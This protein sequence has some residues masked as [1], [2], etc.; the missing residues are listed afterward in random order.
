[1]PL[2]L[3]QVSISV[4]CEEQW[5]FLSLAKAD[6]WDF[7]LSS[8]WITLRTEIITPALA[9]KTEG[10]QV[11]QQPLARIFRT[12]DGIHLLS[13]LGKWQLKHDVFGDDQ[14][15]SVRQLP[16]LLWNP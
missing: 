7:F 6:N 14:R 12:N 16:G 3:L 15:V 5:V 13:Y 8:Q 11:W 2:D 9:E 4:I 10:D 1:M